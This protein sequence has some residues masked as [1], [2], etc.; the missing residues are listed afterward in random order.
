MRKN[1]INA[2]KQKGKKFTQAYMA[3][4]LNIATTSYQRIEA[5]TRNTTPEKWD[6]L[7]DLLGVPQR[8]LRDTEKSKK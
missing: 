7:E 3:K 5:G 4:Q 1:L 8:Q 6:K 2:R